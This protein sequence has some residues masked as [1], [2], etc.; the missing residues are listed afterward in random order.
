M[1][2]IT[3]HLKLGHHHCRPREEVPQNS[4]KTG[5]KQASILNPVLREILLGRWS[6][7]ISY[8]KV[9]DAALLVG[10]HSKLSTP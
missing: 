7:H 9:F 2:Q 6:A 10:L 3:L 4:T 1:L 8:F 5:T